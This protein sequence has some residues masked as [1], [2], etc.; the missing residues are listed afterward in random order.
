MQALISKYQL[1]HL[2]SF[3]KKGYLVYGTKREGGKDIFD[4]I[5][6]ADKI[7]IPTPKTVIPFKKVLFDNERGISEDKRKIAFFGIASCDALAIEL[8]KKEFAGKNLLAK[9]ILVISSECRPDDF[10][11]CGAFGLKKPA[12]FDL[13]VQKEKSGYRI[14]AGSKQGAKILDEVGIKTAPK[15]KGLKEIPNSADTIDRDELSEA[16]SDRK[17]NTDFWQGVTNNCFSCGACAAVCPL[18]FCSRQDFDNKTDGSCNQCLSWDACF[19]KSFFEIQNRYNFRPEP[20]DRLYNWYHHKFVRSYEKKGYFLCTGCG[21]CIE[22][23]PA[24]L[25]QHK[26]ISSII[27]KEEEK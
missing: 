2:F 14:F 16:V 11:F 23:C 22:A 15:E 1:G 10:C 21:R 3:I 6:D 18:C 13:H 4:L 27:S 8:F 9:N 7:I 24:H 19:S 5:T 12:N 17:N 20:A 26:I 25:N